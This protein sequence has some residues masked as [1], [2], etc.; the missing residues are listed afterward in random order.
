MDSLDVHV[1]S[2]ELDALNADKMN[3]DIPV[4]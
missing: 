4:L 1:P 3:L 2:S